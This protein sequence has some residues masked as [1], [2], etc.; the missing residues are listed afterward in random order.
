MKN[1]R[2]NLFEVHFVEKSTKR[3]LQKDANGDSETSIS[4]K[5]PET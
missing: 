5:Q 1:T 3:R 4:W 2:R